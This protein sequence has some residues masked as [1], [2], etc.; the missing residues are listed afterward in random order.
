MSQ[1]TRVII[2]NQEIDTWSNVNITYPG[3]NQINSCQ[4]SGLPTNLENARFFN[5]EIVIYLHYNDF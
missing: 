3:N 1:N 4:V 2:N 5:T